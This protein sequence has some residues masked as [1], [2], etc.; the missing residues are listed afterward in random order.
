MALEKVKRN[1][2]AAARVKT[3]WDLRGITGRI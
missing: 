3:A 2:A 1:E